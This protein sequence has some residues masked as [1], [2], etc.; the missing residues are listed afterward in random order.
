MSASQTH[1]QNIHHG[2]FAYILASLF[3]IVGVLLLL[4][5]L[6]VL[7]SSMLCIILSW[8]SLIILCG[9]LLMIRRHWFVGFII[10]FTGFYFMEPLLGLDLG[11]ISRVHVYWAVICIALGLY[12]LL[13]LFTPKKTKTPFQA[14]TSS[15]VESPLQSNLQSQFQTDSTH[16]QAHSDASSQAH[17]EKDSIHHAHSASSNSHIFGRYQHSIIKNWKH[18]HITKD[19]FVYSVNIFSDAVHLVNETYFTGANIS[20]VF[21]NT[22][23]DLRK[24]KLKNTETFIDLHCI[25]GA[26]TIF[27]PADWKLIFETQEILADTKDSRLP[28]VEAPSSETLGNKKI[29]ILRGTVILGNVEI[30]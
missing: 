28:F 17:S 14:Y 18:I 4:S 9:L 8:Q 13:R 30:R 27:V 16:A 29:L 7:S 15:S 2:Y 22:R 5:S 26:I 11:A 20:T 3:V 12:L 25:L 1:K 21:A 24:V 6:G 19:G 10:L 23:L